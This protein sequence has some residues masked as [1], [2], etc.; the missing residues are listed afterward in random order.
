[1]FVGP[2]SSSFRFLFSSLLDQADVDV[3]VS[4]IFVVAFVSVLINET[5]VCWVSPYNSTPVKRG[6]A[7]L[8][9][10]GKGQREDGHHHL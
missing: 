8:E 1:M 5:V 4:C 6:T 3:F 2:I 10:D 7:T 9:Q